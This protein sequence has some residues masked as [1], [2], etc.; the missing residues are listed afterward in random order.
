MNNL[1]SLSGKWYSHY[2]TT[3]VF[4]FAF[5]CG[6]G[7]PATFLA[8]TGPSLVTKAQSRSMKYKMIPVS[9]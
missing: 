9:P 3:A 4:I 7:M 2:N 6:K 8:P 1:I 5:F